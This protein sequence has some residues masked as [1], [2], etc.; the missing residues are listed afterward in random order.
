MTIYEVEAAKCRE[1]SAGF[2]PR[3]CAE[4]CSCRCHWDWA[5][6]TGKEKDSDD[7]SAT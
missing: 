1:R 4:F 7:D 6:V 5:Y 3:Y 2:C